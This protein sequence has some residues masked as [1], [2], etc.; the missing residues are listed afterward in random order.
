MPLSLKPIGC[1]VKSMKELFLLFILVLHLISVS[2]SLVRPSD[3]L[4]MAINMN[5]RPL[6][7]YI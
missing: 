3:V 6:R 2:P 4:L 7:E 1:E 5:L